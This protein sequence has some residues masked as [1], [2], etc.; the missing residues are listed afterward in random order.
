M[1]SFPAALATGRFFKYTAVYDIK[2]IPKGD[3]PLIYLD[4]AA[5]TRPCPEAVE[6]MRLALTENWGNPSATHGPGREARQ[7]LE[8]SRKSVLNALKAKNG[9]LIFTSGGT[10]ADNQALKCAA[11]QARHRGK[12]IIS[13]EAEHEAVLNSLRDLAAEGWEVTLLK[14]DETG[15][16]PV[17]AVAE[18]LRED[19]VL[20]SLMLVNNETG[21]V[22]DLPGVQE[23]M[24]QK[25]SSALL[26][27]DAVQAFTK[28]PL[29]PDRLGVD[30]ISLSG[31]K[32]GGPKGIGALWLRQGLKLPPLLHG[33]GQ[34]GNLRSG[35]E[36]MP[37]IA[38]FGAAARAAAGRDTA[39][40]AETYASLRRLLAESLPEAVLIGGTHG[41]C[42][43]HICCVSFPGC[44][45][46]VLQN[47]LD[48]QGV[49]VSRGSACAKGRRSHVLEAM[50]LPPAVI[51]G[52]LRVSFSPETTE[53]DVIEFCRLVKEAKARFFR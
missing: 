1:G 36:P 21:A 53:E 30:M 25:G 15:R 3:I 24:R 34:E 4:N 22:N 8:D 6:A 29:A 41:P 17:E 26:H 43:G 13:S 14:P 38:G 37:A 5:T 11:R 45:A 2:S 7:L 50:G 33:G 48:S 44:R 35:T 9:T 12:H 40:A 27:T 47:W 18:A 52:A 31:H 42:A 32:I 49:C 28:L 20:V 51:D 16:I 46:E 23:M 10:E 39:A 19:T